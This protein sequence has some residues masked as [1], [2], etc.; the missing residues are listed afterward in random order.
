MTMATIGRR[1]KKAAITCCRPCLR[2]AAPAG[3]CWCGCRRVSCRRCRGVSVTVC[4][5]RSCGRD[6]STTCVPRLESVRDDP[7]GCRRASPSVTL[8]RLTLPSSPTTR[9]CEA[10]C[11]SLTARCGTSS[12]FRTTCVSACTRP[13]WPGRRVCFGFG[14]A[15]LMRIV[16]VRGSICRSAARN[17]PG[18]GYRLP[19]ASVSCRPVAALPQRLARNRLIDLIGDRR[20]TPAR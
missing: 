7:R 5:S 8:R 16:P 3:F 19:S 6:P 14:N 15:A 18:S 4:P 12:A 9:S 2:S 13:Y 1:T 11:S 17:A 10:P 20:D